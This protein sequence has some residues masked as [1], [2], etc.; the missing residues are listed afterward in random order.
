MRKPEEHNTR[1]CLGGTRVL[2]VFGRRHWKRG[3][4]V[5][6]LRCAE[7]KLKGEAGR[8]GV[9]MWDPRSF[10][11]AALLSWHLLKAGSTHPSAG[12]CEDLPPDF[13]SAGSRLS[14]Q[15]AIEVLTLWP[16]ASLCLLWA[17]AKGPGSVTI[18]LSALGFYT[19]SIRLA[20]MLPCGIPTDQ[21][22]GHP[23]PSLRKL[24]VGSSISGHYPGLPLLLNG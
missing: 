2:D 20:P 9:D 15:P 12:L 4:D 1:S 11:Q 5:I 14:S 7:N 18:A 21:P 10:L 17:P 23:F 13:R 22:D 3:N 16:Y 24:E 6:L 8:K 19:F